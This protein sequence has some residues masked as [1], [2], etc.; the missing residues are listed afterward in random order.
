[1]VTVVIRMNDDLL[2]KIDR[3]RQM[4]ETV[5]GWPVSRNALMVRALDRGVEVFEQAYGLQALTPQPPEQAQDAPVEAIGY[6]EQ[7]FFLGALC[8]RQHD[9]QGTGQS[10]RR[11][12]GRSCWEC[13]KMKAAEKREERR[14]AKRQ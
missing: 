4:A 12:D 6:D 10:L 1:M 14:Q 5:S 8:A 13:H 3:A 9:F 7:K 2:A 11:K